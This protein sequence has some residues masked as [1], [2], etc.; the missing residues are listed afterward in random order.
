MVYAFEF[1]NRVGIAVARHLLGDRSLSYYQNFS[2][3]LQTRNF[4]VIAELL[5]L[6][7]LHSHPSIKVCR[8]III[9]VTLKQYLLSYH[10][11][12]AIIYYLLF[13]FCANNAI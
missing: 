2:S 13:I 1:I 11:E 5:F 4:F 8:T 3:I 9:T 10:Y 6:Q 7:I 12:F